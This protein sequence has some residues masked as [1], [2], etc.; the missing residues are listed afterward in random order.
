MVVNLPIFKINNNTILLLMRIGRY[1]INRAD[2]LLTFGVFMIHTITPH[3]GI[4]YKTYS[5]ITLALRA[6]PKS[7][8][9]T[10][11]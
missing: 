3:K 8:L 9:Q 2:K 1:L 5:V 10:Q 11:S 6:I 7:C 4:E